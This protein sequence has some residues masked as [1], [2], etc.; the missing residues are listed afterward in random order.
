MV[1]GWCVSGRMK[2]FALAGPSHTDGA[3]S[4]RVAQTYPA[5]ANCRSV[6]SDPSRRRASKVDIRRIGAKRCRTGRLALDRPFRVG[7]SR[8]AN[9]LKRPVQSG[10][11]RSGEF[12]RG[13]RAGRAVRRSRRHLLIHLLVRGSPSVSTN[14]SSGM[15]DY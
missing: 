9:T 13:R 2:P 6:K 7:K 12:R 14:S 11:R 15:N 8:P 5:R 3:L 1:R 4:V 10:G